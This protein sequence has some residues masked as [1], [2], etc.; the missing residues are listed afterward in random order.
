MQNR[1]SKENEKD[2]YSKWSS[3]KWF[4][5]SNFF[6]YLFPFKQNG[7]K[8]RYSST[9]V[10]QQAMVLEHPFWVKLSS[11]D[12]RWGCFQAFYFCLCGFLLINHNPVIYFYRFPLWRSLNSNLK[13]Y[14]KKNY[15]YT[16][17]LI[18]LGNLRNRKI[19]HGAYYYSP[20]KRNW[21]KL[22]RPVT[23]D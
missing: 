1:N 4:L 22:I 9:Q 18:S 5:V 21:L 3:D 7:I 17:L 11:Y 20:I 10:L 12:N 13:N 15:P 23:Y 14:Y 19:Y 6:N 2:K 8:F 16:S